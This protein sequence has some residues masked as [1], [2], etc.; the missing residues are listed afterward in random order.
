MVTANFDLELAL[1]FRALGWL[2]VVAV[3]SIVSMEHPEE[4]VRGYQLIN[5]ADTQRVLWRHHPGTLLGSVKSTVTAGVGELLSSVVSPRR[6]L[7]GLQRLLA[8]TRIA[9]RQEQR[10]ALAALQQ[11]VA[12]SPP[13]SNSPAKPS[14]SAA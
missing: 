14:R 5:G 12:K 9:A 7:H 8:A 11:G 13:P 2:N 6:G 3:N 4:L 1:S 10:L